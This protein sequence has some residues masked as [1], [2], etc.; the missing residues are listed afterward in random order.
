MLGHILMQAVAFAAEHQR[1]RG[2]KLNF[3]VGLLAALVEAV[4]Q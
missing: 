1:R 3:V 4:I 2:R